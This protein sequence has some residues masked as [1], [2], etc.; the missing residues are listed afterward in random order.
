MRG[1]A[2]GSP[3]QKHMNVFCSKVREHDC[4]PFQRH[5]RAEAIVAVRLGKSWLR[6]SSGVVDG[7]LISKSGLTAS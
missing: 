1:E 2:M 5:W 4:L 7:T 3:D 6:A